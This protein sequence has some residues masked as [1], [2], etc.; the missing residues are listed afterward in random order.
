[1]FNTTTG[2]WSATPR[3]WETGLGFL[4]MY[5]AKGVNRQRS[6]SVDFKKNH[7]RYTSPLQCVDHGCPIF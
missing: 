2:V 7:K 4:N 5:N 6:G 3:L 1:M